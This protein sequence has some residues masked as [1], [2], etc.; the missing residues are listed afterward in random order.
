MPAI[1]SHISYI[2]FCLENRKT[3]TFSEFLLQFILD[4]LCLPYLVLQ[5]EDFTYLRSLEGE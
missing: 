3:C 5:S 4:E 1:P 2:L